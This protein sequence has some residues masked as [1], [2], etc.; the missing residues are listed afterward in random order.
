[1]TFKVDFSQLDSEAT[2]NNKL[3]GRPDE[4]AYVSARTER[5][6]GWLSGYARVSKRG[7]PHVVITKDS[8]TYSVCWFGKGRFWRIFYPYPSWGRD[9]NKLD[10]QTDE[11]VLTYFGKS[12]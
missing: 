2:D 3:R 11:E 4:V 8:V 12:R 9:Q 10:I 7:V 1:M 5:M 6:A